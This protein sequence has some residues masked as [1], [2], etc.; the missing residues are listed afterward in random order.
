M[1]RGVSAGC[2]VHVVQTWSS[3]GTI[4][5]LLALIFCLNG[6]TALNINGM[7]SYGVKFK[8]NTEPAW[9]GVYT[10]VWPWF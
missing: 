7:Y 3:G 1:I 4:R 9:C 6:I 8:H 2:V 5:A 10:G